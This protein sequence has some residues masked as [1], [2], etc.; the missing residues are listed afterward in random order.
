M[1]GRWAWPSHIRAE[2]VAGNKSI[3]YAVKMHKNPETGERHPQ[4]RHPPSAALWYF[5]VAPLSVG[6]SVDVYVDVYVRRVC[7]GCGTLCSGIFIF[8][9]FCT[10]CGQRHRQSPKP[11]ARKL[12][13]AVILV[14]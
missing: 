11:K 6:V 8:E 13:C 5:I 1:H 2:V 12:R 10:F 7:G 9:N 3:C 4:R 14:K